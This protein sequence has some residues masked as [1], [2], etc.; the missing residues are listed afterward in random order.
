M[1][2]VTDAMANEAAGVRR[3]KILSAINKAS[4]WMNALGFG[5]LAPLLKLAA[6]DNPREQLSELKTALFIPL[7]GIMGFILAWAA[8]APQVQTSLGA[9]VT[10]WR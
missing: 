6:G 2:N 1:A 9:A 8:L 10:C 7:I 5:W 4:S 3:E